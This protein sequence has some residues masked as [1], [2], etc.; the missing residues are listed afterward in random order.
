[1]SGRNHNDLCFQAKNQFITIL[2]L[3]EL[4]WE[5]LLLLILRWHI[6]CDTFLLLIWKG[7]NQEVQFDSEAAFPVEHS[8]PKADLWVSVLKGTKEILTTQYLL[9]E[10][11]FKSHIPHNKWNWREITWSLQ[12]LPLPSSQ[13]QV[14]YYSKNES[15]VF[16]AVR[17]EGWFIIW[18]IGENVYRVPALPKVMLECLPKY[19]NVCCKA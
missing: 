9:N 11:I 6:V 5:T 14:R 16:T 17:D 10:L 15:I 13:S 12:V 18:L 19:G 1:M 8:W 4:I 7:C 2:L 3:L